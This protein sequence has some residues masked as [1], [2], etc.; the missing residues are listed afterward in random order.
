MATPLGVGRAELAEPLH[1]VGERV[2]VELRLEP[3]EDGVET[4]QE[5]GCRL[6]GDPPVGHEDGGCLGRRR[7]ACPYVASVATTLP[8]RNAR[9]STS[10]S[11]R[12]VVNSVRPPPS[13]TGMITN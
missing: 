13:A 1:P 7:P 5:A 12:P 11:W 9:C 8:Q 4:R 3:I 6:L 10:R 2:P